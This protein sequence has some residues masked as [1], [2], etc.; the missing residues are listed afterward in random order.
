M[1][2]QSNPSSFFNCLRKIIKD[3]RHNNNYSE[4]CEKIKRIF[5]DILFGLFAI[6]I[7]LIV[8]N[9][10]PTLLRVNIAILSLLGIVL[11]FLGFF[12]GAIWQLSD[13]RDGLARDFF[14][15][16]AVG[17]IF[18][19][20][21]QI[22]NFQLF[23]DN[24]DILGNCLIFI[25]G[26]LF[27]M[28]IGGYSRVG[29]SIVKLEKTTDKM[30]LSMVTSILDAQ[31]SGYL[32]DQQNKNIFQKERSVGI[33]KEASITFPEYNEIINKFIEHARISIYATFVIPPRKQI[34]YRDI[35]PFFEKFSNAAVTTEKRAVLVPLATQF[36]FWKETASDYKSS[37]L[38]KLVNEWLKTTNG[39]HKVEV[40]IFKDYEKDYR[41]Y[42]GDILI[43]DKKIALSFTPHE[44][45]LKGEMGSPSGNIQ[46]MCGN[47][48]GEYSQIFEDEMFK[49]KLVDPEAFYYEK[50][51]EKIPNGNDDPS[52]LS[53]NI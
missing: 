11:F 50:L 13:N 21:F 49:L 7:F 34:G 9:I 4:N 36:E 12:S 25:F 37:Y 16:A 35:K 23:K 24:W 22:L 31:L 6:I 45:F 10:Y 28:L 52:D 30:Y 27:A 15:N 8:L 53:M 46:I 39:T 3:I 44:E 48:V 17:I 14:L 2:N 41:Q 26:F 18:V 20:F 43:I 38:F 33:C 40:K 47:I 51:K 1:V 5:I 32:T 19:A 29:S 42:Y